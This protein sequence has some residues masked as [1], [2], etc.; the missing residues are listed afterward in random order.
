MVRFI[1]YCILSLFLCSTSAK[2]H[3]ILSGNS[4]KK[5]IVE[6]LSKPS[7]RAGDFIRLLQ[8]DS[9]IEA[10]FYYDIGLINISIYDNKSGVCVYQAD[11]DT[12]TE[13]HVFIDLSFCNKGKYK[14]IL[15]ID[16]NT[17]YGE[18]EL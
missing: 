10:F 12:N 13:E 11:V 5:I 14:I 17:L 15:T 2:E 8:E 7:T 4:K 6:D 9:R 16:K 3:D 18:F 1:S